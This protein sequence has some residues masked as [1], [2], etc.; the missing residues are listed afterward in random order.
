[1]ERIV[2][3][4]MPVQP[5]T[6]QKSRRRSRPRWGAPLPPAQK[7]E[8]TPV[9]CLPMPCQVRRCTLHTAHRTIKTPGWSE[10]WNGVTATQLDRES[11]DWR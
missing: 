1:M 6:L 8:I 3:A 2:T 10:R 11:D 7:P 5:M 9:P 4:V